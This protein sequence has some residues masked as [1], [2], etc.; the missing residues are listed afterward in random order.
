MNRKTERESKAFGLLYMILGCT[1]NIILRFRHNF[2]WCIS[3]NF[4]I[5]KLILDS[6]YSTILRYLCITLCGI[7][8]IILSF[9]YPILHLNKLHYVL[10][11]L[12][13]VC[14]NR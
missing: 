10:D 7:C 8:S 4:K 5:L 9:L 2:R 13:K 12:V 14:C 11:S 1:H 3:H 6:E